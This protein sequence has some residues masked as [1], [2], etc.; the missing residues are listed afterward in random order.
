MITEVKREQRAEREREKR[1]FGLWAAEGSLA[2]GIACAEPLGLCAPFGAAFCSG[3]EAGGGGLCCLFGAMA[4]CLLSRGMDR[5]LRYCAACLLSF[6]VHFVFRDTPALERKWFL[7]ASVG[8]ISLL[9]GSLSY[10]EGD[11][12]LPATLKLLTEA[13]MGAA[14]A[15]YFSALR[16]GGRNPLGAEDKNAALGAVLLFC[17]CVGALCRIRLPG[18]LT[19]GQLPAVVTV[20]FFA[21]SSGAE[22]G[23]AA[24]L[25][26]GLSVWQRG[27][28]EGLALSLALAG[29]LG[30]VMRK[31]KGWL[32]AFFF[33]LGFFP[34]LAMGETR[35]Q[36][37]LLLL[38][39]LALTVF[40]A[41]PKRL[42]RRWGESFSLPEGA[43]SEVLLRRYGAL[44]TRDLAKTFR[45][46][47]ESL[48][49]SRTEGEDEDISEVYD[50][51]AES[52]CA[53][54]Q[55]KDICWHTEYLRMVSGLRE[56]TELLRKRGKLS[57]EELPAFF[58]EKCLQP[59]SFLRSVNAELRFAGYRRQLRARLEENRLAAYSQ[60]RILSSIL[61]ERSRELG[62]ERREDRPLERRVYRYLYTRGLSCRVSAYRDGK[63]KLGILLEGEDAA[64]LRERE[65]CLAGLSEAVGVPLFRIGGEKGERRI[66]LREQESYAA[67]LAVAAAKKQGESVSGD[68]GTWFRT[69]K[70]RLCLLISDGMGSGEEASAEAAATVRALESLLRCG[71]EPDDALA[72]VNGLMLV[73]NGDSWAYAT[74]DLLTVDLFTGTADFYKFGAAPSYVRTAGSVKRVRGS[75][76]AAGILSGENEERETLTTRL[77]A[78]DM[79]VL[80]SDGVAAE[81]SDGWLRE[82]LGAFVGSDP[83]VLA[84][85]LLE[86]AERQYG[87]CDDMTVIVMLL[88]GRGEE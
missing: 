32:F 79:V 7:P 18:S 67:R 35:R 12:I 24:G 87:R 56:V 80:C 59:E 43:E 65:G 49:E 83:K 85:E 45:E 86:E 23:C 77:G 63:G 54:C 14:G 20:L 84:K 60:L 2:L 78:G 17:A 1:G 72:L 76:L 26:M 19:L 29:F 38:P 6:T 88:E 62:E 10:F 58:R 47:Y 73:K 25:V 71:V 82:R 57:G 75:A 34:L 42:R 44:C 30:G 66:L 74:V 48:W 27:G 64:A 8:L 50:R 36:L 13:G 21:R 9:C 52:V 28:D 68:R 41:L 16:K 46:L 15:F 4:G 81:Q 51:A 61:E 69:E 53:N 22:R 37:A 40:F 70:G 39:A 5:G 11:A 3:A 55:R 31:R 33:A